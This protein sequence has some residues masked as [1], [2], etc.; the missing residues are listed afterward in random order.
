MRKL[1]AKLSN[2]LSRV[3]FNELWE[4]F[5]FYDFALYNDKEVFLKDKVIPYDNRFIG[6][7]AI[8]YEGQYLA[9]WNVENPD[10]EDIEVLAACIVHEMFHAYQYELKESRWPQDLR[11]LDYPSDIENFKLKY[12][13]NKILVAAYLEKDKAKKKRLLTQFVSIRSRREA[14]IGDIIRCEYLSETAEGMAE[15]VGIMALKQI[16]TEKYNARMEEYISYLSTESEL[17]FD[18]RRISYFSGAVLLVIVSEVGI[19]F[20]HQIG[21]CNS[22]VFEIVSANFDKTATVEIEDANLIE[23]MANKYFER[24]RAKF[25]DFFNADRE[26][27]QGEFQIIGYDPMNMIKIDNR[28]LCSHFIMLKDK[29]TSAQIFLN[30]PVV[31]ELEPKTINKVI[32]YFK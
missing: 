13:E 25:E 8:N 17:F 29:R 24:K 31:V 7:T 26:Y 11:T 6:N 15:Y 30:G 21:N 28:I 5:H 16:S 18:T 23:E 3:N 2:L 27:V 14:I 1:Y 20:Y 19:S 22:S 4:G 32:T 12:A 9:I 10:K